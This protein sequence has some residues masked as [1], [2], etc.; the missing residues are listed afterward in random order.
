VGV[1]LY[2]ILTGNVPTGVPKAASQ[3]AREVPPALDPIVAKCVDP[4]PEKRYQSAAELRAALHPII[5][6]LESG[7]FVAG[8]VGQEAPARINQAMVRK[9][10]GVVLMLLILGLAGSALYALEKART[11]QDHQSEI[12]RAAP[13]AAETQD[14]DVAFTR[15]SERIARA[16]SLAPPETGKN[17]DIARVQ[18]YARARWELAQAEAERKNTEAVDLARQALQCYV[19]LRSWQPGMVFVPPGEVTMGDATA[20]NVL[21]LDGFFIDVYEVTN[22]QYLEF[23][24]QVEGGWRWPPSYNLQEAPPNMPVVDVTFYDAL[25]YAAWAG[26]QLPTEAQWARAAYGDRTVPDRYPWGSEWQA[27]AC[28]SGTDEDAYEFAAPTGSFEK[29]RTWSGCYDMAGNVSEWTRTEF[30]E[31]PYDPSDERD[32]PS[33]F[34]F[35]TPISARGGNLRDTARTT[36]NARFSWLFEEHDS[37]LG[38]RCV[39]ELPKEA[40]DAEGPAP[41]AP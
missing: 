40:E 20:S 16:R 18:E 28:N 39:N 34:T 26:K 15:L 21:T 3:L 13:G 17:E 8:P 9:A 32:D 23:C 5:G 2:E 10:A 19:A 12:I 30:K 6:L 1:V 22:G 4:D 11:E 33:R 29:D 36:L 38:F 41:E 14:F 24:T 27:G 31:L 25:A 37:T 35:G 7:S